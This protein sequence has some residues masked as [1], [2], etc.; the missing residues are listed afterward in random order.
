MGAEREQERALIEK[1]DWPWYPMLPVKRDSLTG[2]MPEVG[3]I[4]ATIE[5]DPVVVHLANLFDSPF[6][7]RDAEKIS[8][9]SLDAFF[10]D[11]W[12]G[13]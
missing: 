8:Y 13:D 7:I 2:G 11:G 9:E 5:W 4:Y 1:M 12:R 10:D 3:I 6:T